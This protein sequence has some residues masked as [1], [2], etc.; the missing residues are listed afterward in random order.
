M[1]GTS[2][3]IALSKYAA[4]A[5]IITPISADDEATR[6]ALGFCGPV[7]YLDEDG[8][9]KFYNHIA[10][11]LCKERIGDAVW[12]ASEKVS[13]VRNPW[14][15]AVSMFYYHNGAAANLNEL[16]QW[17]FDGR[18]S[19]YLT[20][21]SDFYFI[22]EQLIID[23]FIRYEHIQQDILQLEQSNTGL[24]G[25]SEIFSGIYAKSGIRD[26]KSRR[27]FEVFSVHTELRDKIA[28]LSAF[29]INRFGYEV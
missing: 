22:D 1:A 26:D 14:D 12:Q 8:K 2:F 21:N 16:S 17:Y 9:P 7:N 5:D 11:K 29:E 28:E 13:I 24:I 18:G 20:G 10:A 27:L 19:R 25:L 4:G 6:N 3:E 15:V 23:R